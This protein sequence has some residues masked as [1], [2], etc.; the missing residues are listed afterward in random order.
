LLAGVVGVGFE[1][2][3]QNRNDGVINYTRVIQTGGLVGGATF[4]GVMV[5]QATQRVLLLNSYNLLG[6]DSSGVGA[7][8]FSGFTGDFL[9]SGAASIFYAG[10]AYTLGWID[11][12]DARTLMAKGVTGSAILAAGKTAGTQAL[13]Y[14]VGSSGA[15]AAFGPYAITY[16]AAVGAV[17]LTDIIFQEFDN[18]ERNELIGRMIADMMGSEN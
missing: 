9:G 6:V 3:D 10:G 15:I 16:L 4:T 8:M 17:Y 1:I 18:R 5:G 13:F 7:Q 11:G 2:Y 12:A 14:T